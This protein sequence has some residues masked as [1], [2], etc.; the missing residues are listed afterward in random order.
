MASTE[1]KKAEQLYRDGMAPAEI[2]KTLGKPLATISSWKRRHGWPA[3]EGATPA[4][5]RKR[6]VAPKP[7]RN[8]ATETLAKMTAAADE[9]PS[10]TEQQKRFCLLY[11]QRPN[12]TRA[13][14]MAF[15]CKAYGTAKVEG[16]RLLTN[17][18]VREEITRQKQIVM[19]QL[20]AD[21]TD[22][23]RL[24][25]DIAFSD[26]GEFV[27]WGR[28]EVPVVAM[29][30]PVMLKNPDD[31]D[32]DKIPLTKEINEVRFID[33][34]QVDTTIV[35]EVKQGRDGASVKLASKEKALQWLSDYFELN[36]SDV[37]RREYDIRRLE[38]ESLKIAV[39]Q[40]GTSGNTPPDD[41]FLAAMNAEAGQMWGGDAPDDSR[42]E[43]KVDDE[44]DTS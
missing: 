19:E 38:L 40:G 11:A 34:G 28:T 18:N 16:C 32:G 25:W 35:A 36:P 1:A 41:G 26:M 42:E 31:P 30:G 37:H 23:F 43:W 27:E 15:E 14:R 10:L 6:N 39:A 7:K 5:Q 33:S 3:Q 20:I 44:L 17:P 13:Y 8:T 24:Y 9:N 29:Y 4:T 2:A 22:I 12:A 21:P